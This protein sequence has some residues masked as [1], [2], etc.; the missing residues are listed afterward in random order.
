MLIIAPLAYFILP[1]DLIPDVFLG[2]GYVDDGVAVMTALKTFASSITPE[3]TDQ[4][5]IMCKNLIG[6]TDENVIN[7]VLDKISQNT[8][9]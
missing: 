3:I 6:E 2:V 8:E 1:A 5:R 9:E 7:G 4:T